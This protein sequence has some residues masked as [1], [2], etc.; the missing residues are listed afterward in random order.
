MIRL[1][2]QEVAK[3]KGIGQG[4]LARMAD[5]DVKTIKR[6]FRDPYVEV[7]TFTLDKIARA[8]GVDVRDLLESVP[9]D[10]PI[11]PIPEDIDLSDE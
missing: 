8:L 2:I 9:G 7:S 3:R 1:K 5:M 10:D 11:H 4:K 6:I